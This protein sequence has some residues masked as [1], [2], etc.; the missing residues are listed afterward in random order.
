M[1]TYSRYL[2]Q[3]GLAI[4]FIGIGIMILQDP[5]GWAALIQPWAAKLIPGSIIS[6]MKETAFLDVGVGILFLIGPIVWI[7]ALI[8]SVHI[9]VVLVTTG[10]TTITIRDVGLLAAALVLFIETVPT[11]VVRKVVF[12]KK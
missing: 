9:A 6:T 7:A 12:W 4:V 2:L 1:K 11:S 5:V 10:I 8:G 3:I